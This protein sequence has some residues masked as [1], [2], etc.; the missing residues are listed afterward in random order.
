MTEIQI[1]EI[2]RYLQ[3]YTLSIVKPMY[4]IR[5]KDSLNSIVQSLDQVV[6]DTELY[7]SVFDKAAHLWYSLINRHCF[8]NGNKRTALATT[9]IF[10]KNQGYNL[11]VD[12]T[13][14]DFSLKIIEQ[15]LEKKDVKE[16]IQEKYSINN[17]EMIF[18]EPLKVLERD[19]E[20]NENFKNVIIRL[21]LT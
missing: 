7:P 2:N 19:L 10:I 6:F 5:D 4:G 18:D 8:Y 1:I 17:Q 20:E 21:S 14:Y 11:L 9:Y 3:D 13:F 12:K 16:F 15:H